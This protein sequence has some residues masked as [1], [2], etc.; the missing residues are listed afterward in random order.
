MQ[1]IPVLDLMGGV[2]VRARRGD[3]ASYRPIETPLAEGAAPAAV[4]KGLLAVHPFPVVYLADL[5]GI[6]QGR[7]DAEA[8]DAI[9]AALPGTTLWVD[10][11]LADQDA[12][13]AFLAPRPSV[14]LVVGSETQRDP[15][16]ARRLGARAVLS[17]DF[18]G[19]T[20][21]GPA[22]LIESP[23]HWPADV[24]VMTLARV[25]AGEG[26]D[27][28]RLR[29]I[30]ARAGASRRVYAAGGVRDEAD[31]LALKAAGIAGALVA[32]ALHDGSLAAP[33]LRRL[34]D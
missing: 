34:S 5:D 29:A 17:L 28:D 20:Y 21:V 2:V 32:T 11:G 19:D 25:G 13:A 26:P 6:M 27:V 15:E 10:N 23:D 7:P 8:V 18:R 1:V 4:A 9:A 22:A 30:K 16:L 33:A 14:R 3:R 31:L 12:A 24:I